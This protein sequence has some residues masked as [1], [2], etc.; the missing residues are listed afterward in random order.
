MFLFAPIRWAFKIVS[1][2]LSVVVLYFG[3][4]LVQV[5]LTGREHADINAQAIVVMGAAQYN[6]VPSPDLASRLTEA[7]LLFKQHRAPLIVVTGSKERGDAYTEAQASA[8]FLAS[9]GVPATAIRQAGGDDSW[10]NLADAASILKPLGAKQVLI[11]TD[12]FHEDRSMAI[13]SAV[14]LDPHSDPTTTS[15]I[16]GASSIPYYLKETVGVG[17]GRLIGFSRLHALG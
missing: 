4:S 16:Q 11:V 1:F 15:P 12:P 13:A 7:A 9:L 5:W 3:V 8:R 14:G 17:L 10:N 6:G 2:F